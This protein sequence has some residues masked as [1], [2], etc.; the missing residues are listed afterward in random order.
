LADGERTTER[1]LILFRGR[2]KRITTHYLISRNM[3]AKQLSLFTPDRLPNKPFC[4]DE[5]GVGETWKIRA[6]DHALRYKHIQ[7]NAPTVI[8]RLIFDI[9][10]PTAAF[11]WEDCN[12]PPFSWAAT[13]PRNGHAHASYEISIPVNFVDATT[14]AARLLV[15]MEKAIG[16][17]LGADPN[18]TG[19]LCKN[20]I[21]SAWR[22]IEFN[23]TPYSL[24]ELAEWV[25]DELRQV[26]KKRIK[27]EEDGYCVG[28]NYLMFERLRKWAYTAVR[29]YWRPGGYEC[30][31]MA[32]EDKL[33]DLWGHEEGNWASDHAYAYSERKATAKSVGKWVWQHL[34]PGGFRDYVAATH[35]PEIQ[36]KRG[37]KGGLAKGQANEE[38]R[39]MALQMAADG[40]RGTDIARELGVSQQSVSNWLK[41]QVTK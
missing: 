12:L 10:R 17:R 33:Q 2:I 4:T 7:P 27:R 16:M 30:W 18:Y 13:N 29:E 31:L 32:V 24:F 37:K 8:F 1:I 5:Y 39:A 26:G 19:R 25:D 35:T 40:K 34:T 3:I 38:K 23:P 6:I 9:D 21:H 22:T 28:R 15:A 20:P 36:A 11:A 41:K 14:K